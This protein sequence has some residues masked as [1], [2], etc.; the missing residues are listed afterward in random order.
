MGQHIDIIAIYRRYRY[1]R[2]FAG[3]TATH[4]CSCSGPP[5]CVFLLKFKAHFSDCTPAGFSLPFSKIINNSI[6]DLTIWNKLSIYQSGQMAINLCKL[7]C[8][9][10]VNLFEILYSE[11][12]LGSIRPSLP[13]FWPGAF[14]NHFE[15]WPSLQAPRSLYR[16]VPNTKQTRCNSV[17]HQIVWHI[18]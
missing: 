14:D 2:V 12:D 1:H 4:W 16:S 6:P 8:T 13:V 5:Q 3:P 10:W 7:K 9:C 18:L 11:C 17:K 15:A